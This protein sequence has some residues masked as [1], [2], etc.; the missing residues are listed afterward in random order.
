[1]SNRQIKIL[2]VAP[3]EGM[4]TM[5]QRLAAE[6]DDID[7][8]V[9]VGD[10]NEGVEIARQNFQ[11]NYDVI[12]S[13]GGTAEMISEIT[14][15][16]LIEINLSVYD[17]LRAIKLAE[18]YS[19]R[20]AIVGYHGITSSAQLLCDLLQYK[21]DIFTIHNVNEVE[22]ILKNLKE[23][24][25]HMVLCDMITK[26]T[27]KHL[28]L[29]AILITSGDE[30]ILSA[31]DQA[32]KLYKTYF[33]IRE[34]NKFLESILR[35]A[36][37]SIVVFDEDKN[38]VFSSVEFENIDHLFALLKKEIYESLLETSR[39]FVKTLDETR[40]TIKS[41]KIINR[42]KPYIAYY[43][44]TTHM[45]MVKGKH[46]I[47]YSNKSEVEDF[48]FNSFYSVTSPTSD[49]KRHLDQ[50]S[51]H[52]SPV[53]VIG[54]VGTG[55]SQI[56]RLLY[57]QSLLANNPFITFDCDLISDKS[58]HFLLNHHDSPLCDAE[59]TLFFKD[60][61]TLGEIRR[62]QLLA[63]ILDSK[64][65][66]RNRIIFSYAVDHL[67]Q[68]TEAATSFINTLSCMTITLKPL[69]ERTDEIAK[70]SSLYISNLN[71]NLAKQI[72][73]FEPQALKR[74]QNYNWP[75][76]YT[77]FK[78]VLEEMTVL[79]TTPYISDK[80]VETVLNKEKIVANTYIQPPTSDN[81]HIVSYVLNTEYTLADIN[82]EIVSLYVDKANG[83]HSLAAKHL[84]I[85]RTTLW[86]YLK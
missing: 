70:L 10:L 85:S 39:K 15:I 52:Q 69:K 6:R 74:L 79:T 65:Y 64:A 11:R 61:H 76:N 71:L 34:E 31:F 77:Q 13:R 60:L 82:K 8:T 5:M 36:D 22:S 23:Q 43:I 16:P 14:S 55:K 72:I 78:R 27:A 68:Y 63:N 25:Y 42:N 54:E 7:L 51:H 4:K 57:T 86:R 84:G 3:Y 17:I 44:Q 26:T 41:K 19:D 29:N 48:F 62:K 66:K 40:F 21:I 30:S 38:L 35:G 50:M 58:W 33:D 80:T 20:Y 9:F 59:N 32:E 56:A 18:N 46:G 73:G 45:P 24:G 1:M 2:G 53:M 37:N 75:T 12:I 28:G 49:L 83:N 81:D 47:K 67:S